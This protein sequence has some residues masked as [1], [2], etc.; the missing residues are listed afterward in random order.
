MLD[1]GDE[2]EQLATESSHLL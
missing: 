2:E 1:D